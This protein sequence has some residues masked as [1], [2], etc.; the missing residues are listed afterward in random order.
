MNW[1]RYL[2]R[3]NLIWLEIGLAVLLGAIAASQAL[4]DLAATFA[5]AGMIH[6]L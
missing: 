6:R 2:K 5:I 3:T 4:A 1:K